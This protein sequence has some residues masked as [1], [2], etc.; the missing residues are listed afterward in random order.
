MRRI[1]LVGLALTVMAAIAST[2]MAQIQRTQLQPIGPVRYQ[3][4]NKIFDYWETSGG[5]HVDVDLPAGFFGPGSDAGSYTIDLVGQPFG[6]GAGQGLPANADTSVRRLKDPKPSG[7]G[8]SATTSIKMRG[9]SLASTSPITVTYNGGGSP[10]FWDVHVGLSSSAPQPW[11]SLTATKTWSGGGT[12]DSSLTVIPEFTFTRVS[13]GTIMVLDVGE[14]S[15]GVPASTITAAGTHYISNYPGKSGAFHP[16]YSQGPTPEQIA[17]VEFSNN[18]AEH[19]AE[20]CEDCPEDG[21]DVEPID[22]HEP[23]E[24]VVHGVH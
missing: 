1:F 4:V 16:G 12:F 21:P 9:L 24:P 7:I 13:N 3:P 22:E 8:Q 19:E 20:P 5:T 17:Y 2:A 18:C 23:F 14:P 10:E 15:S 6:P 11:G